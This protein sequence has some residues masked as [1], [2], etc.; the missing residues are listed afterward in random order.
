MSTVRTVQARKRQ[1]GSSGVAR[2]HAL[3]LGHPGGREPRPLGRIKGPS[4]NTAYQASM[5]PRRAS[6]EY[7]RS[8]PAVQDHNGV[9][10]AHG[11]SVGSSW[12]I[13]KKEDVQDEALK[14]MLTK[15]SIANKVELVKPTR[16]VEYPS[17]TDRD[18][19]LADKPLPR[20]LTILPDALGTKEDFLSEIEQYQALCEQR[21]SIR[22]QAEKE[23]S[24][25][26]RA[27]ARRKR[28]ALRE[29]SNA[30]KLKGALSRL[31]TKE[32]SSRFYA[33]RAYTKKMKRARKM[34]K[35]IM[36]STVKLCWR[37]W[38]TYV[39][40]W[41]FEK[42]CAA[43]AIQSVV[44]R[45]AAYQKI[46]RLIARHGAATKICAIARV[47][48]VKGLLHV[49][50]DKAIKRDLIV[51]QSLIGLSGKNTRRFFHAWVDRVK[52]MK[53][54]KL[55]SQHFGARLVDECW[56]TWR[57]NAKRLRR[58]RIKR[59]QATIQR[60]SRGHLARKRVR[61][62]R[63]EQ[64]AARRIQCTFRASQARRFVT[65]KAHQYRMIVKKTQLMLAGTIQ[66]S[67]SMWIS[68]THQRK[69]LKRIGLGT[70]HRRLV[71]A[72]DRWVERRFFA[73]IIQ[74]TW[75]GHVAKRVARKLRLDN[76]VLGI[77]LENSDEVL[78]AQRLEALVEISREDGLDSVTLTRLQNELSTVQKSEVDHYD[79]SIHGAEQRFALPKHRDFLLSVLEREYK[80]EMANLRNAYKKS[81]EKESDLVKAWKGML[82]EYIGSGI[83]VT[84]DDCEAYNN[85]GKTF[86]LKIEDAETV[87]DTLVRWL[88]MNAIGLVTRPVMLN[89]VVEG[90]LLGASLEKRQM[91]W[92]TVCAC[93]ER[94]ILIDLAA[95]TLQRLNQRETMSEI[96]KGKVVVVE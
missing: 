25:T 5:S 14:A 46:A 10:Q 40:D 59:S 31:K 20:L 78:Q 50:R 52:L 92:E 44:R 87:K 67:F 49:I 62:I 7:G 72:F 91:A 3:V 76:I 61:R 4:A 42:Q 30:T 65:Q 63:A 53:K 51:E 22:L 38:G 58:V 19:I 80:K 82:Q 96:E 6:T 21:E 93:F 66:Y 26:L 64:S 71:D 11:P 90:V 37:A 68:F 69:T 18:A 16:L 95:L 39:I 94:D 29:G 1:R 89:W 79:L 43:C 36:A 84:L 86:H 2:Q 77:N 34:C 45:K 57:T 81:L 41:Q 15:Q 23:R 33:W 8:A 54:V 83:A 48:L 13:A 60:V 74:R 88:E 70:Q 12:D 75:R 35:R 32:A 55:M 73:L 47:F 24:R 17:G 56:I 9:N 85:A 28:K 27:E